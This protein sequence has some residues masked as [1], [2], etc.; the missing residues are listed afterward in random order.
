LFDGVRLEKTNEKLSFWRKV[1]ARKA[2]EH[3][4]VS[5]K[6]EEFNIEFARLRA[7]A[8]LT[9]KSSSQA[10]RAQGAEQRPFTGFACLF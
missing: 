4:E 7:E 1:Y 9:M 5:S 2:Q 10:E 3:G 6:Y 8:C